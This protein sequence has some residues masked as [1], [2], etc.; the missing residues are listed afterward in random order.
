MVD[1]I[2]CKYHSVLSSTLE[3]YRINVDFL[4]R[5]QDMLVVGNRVYESGDYDPDHLTNPINESKCPLTKELPMTPDEVTMPDK[6]NHPSHYT[7]LKDKCGIEVIDITRHLDFCTGNAVK[8][9]LR[10]GHKEEA[11]MTSVEKEIEDLKKAKWYIDDKINEL[12]KENNLEEKDIFKQRQNN[13]QYTRDELL[14]E[15]LW[16]K[17]CQEK[18]RGSGF[19]LVCQKGYEPTYIQGNVYPYISFMS[20]IHPSAYVELTWGEFYVW[21][22]DCKPINL[23]N[24]NIR[25]TDEIIKIYSDKEKNKESF[26]NFINFLMERKVKLW[27]EGQS[28]FNFVEMYFGNV[29]RKVQFE[30]GIDCFYNNENI[31]SFL[32]ASWKR[33]SEQKR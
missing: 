6:V 24:E 7:W 3:D 21:Y 31:D 30:D 17:Y 25:E 32:E 26:M 18:E 4:C 33:I 22:G 14:S 20:D 9:L 8:Y 15:L 2:N 12:M 11:D 5:Q 13:F 10:A 19:Y 29:A 28:V 16:A 23:K 1:C 27:R